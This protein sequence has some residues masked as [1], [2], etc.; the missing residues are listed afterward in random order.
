MLASLTEF[1][2]RKIMKLCMHNEIDMEEVNFKHCDL[3][4]QV[5]TKNLS[6]LHRS[7]LQYHNPQKRRWS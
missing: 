1:S 3:C 4:S 6:K 5:A 2:E 7:A